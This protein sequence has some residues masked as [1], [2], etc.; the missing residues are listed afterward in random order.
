MKKALML[1]WF[2]GSLSSALAQQRLSND[3]YQAQLLGDGAV[4][5]KAGDSPA[6]KFRPVFTVMFRADDPDIKQTFPPGKVENMPVPNWKAVHGN[7]RTWDFFQAAESANVVASKAE[8][9]RAGKVRWRFAGDGPFQLE[10]ELSLAAGRGEP[11]IAFRFTPKRDGWYSIGY[12]G[13]PQW[14]PSELDEVWQPWIWQEKRF[15]RQSFFSSEHMCPLPATLIRKGSVTV[16]VAADP[17]ESPYRMPNR[18]NARFGVLVRNQNGAAQPMIFAPVLGRAASQMKAGEAFTFKLRLLVHAGTIFDAYKHLARN[19]YGFRDY[20]EN[21]GGSLNDTLENFISYA[22]NDYYS[23]WVEELKGFDYTSDVERTVKVVSALHPLSLAFITDNEE[24]Y[25]RRALPIIE[26]LMSREKY[27]FSIVEGETRQ[28]PSHALKG[29]AAE[30]SELAALYLMSQQRSDVFRHYALKL[31]DKRRAL[32]LEVVSEGASWQSLLG[33]YRMTGDALYLNRAKEGADRYI[34]ER[35]N[36]PQ[37]DFSA[38]NPKTGW[39]FW[40][41]YTPKWIDLLELYEE[42]REQRYLE[43][44]AV[45]ARLYTNYVWL[46]PRIPPGSVIANKGNKA[47]VGWRR[48]SRDPQ[49]MAVPEQ[50]VPAWRLSQI[51]LTPEASNTFEGN[52][53]VFLTHYAAYF[54]RLAYYTGDTFFRDIARAAV[55][56]RYENY[57]GYDINVEFTTLYARP[58]YPLRPYH[59]FTYN[60]VYY[61]HVWPHIALLMDYLLTEAFTKSEGR[62]EFPPRYAE[63]YAYLKSKVYGDRPGRF[64][65]DDGVRLWMPAKL[66]R[67]DN[68][69]AN[70]VAGYGNGNLYLALVNQSD[71]TIDVKLRLNP[72]VVPFDEAKSYRVRVW[73]ENKTAH[74]TTMR[75]G[76][77]GVTIAPRGITALAVDGLKVTPLFQPQVFNAGAARLSAASHAEI[78]TPFGKLTSMLI[79]FGS[80][81]TSGYVWLE[82]TEKELK[83]ARLNV[84]QDGEW[85]QMIDAQYPFEFSLP[86]KGDDPNIEFWVEGVTLDGRSVR[87]ASVA[88]KK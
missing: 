14:P 2:L 57:P 45:G 56:G 80:S 28:S 81:L 70:Y 63:G 86:V 9:T 13:A 54:L 50:F 17:D 1:I 64:Y 19:L 58:D 12:T 21:V 41:D 43:A 3:H 85:K 25:R 16:G 44:A 72:N 39:E 79:S 36:R 33:L 88:L 31:L 55:V 61:N 22:M 5:L 37:S 71:K 49:P 35:I 77:I 4:E 24:I 29:P 7:D 74:G 84:K 52:P 48:A 76:E 15:P 11:L 75:H 6:Y 38:I 32:N 30:I 42:T 83:E 47:A 27:L 78:N 51:G 23:G 46:H 53:A 65:A 26:Y 40:V 67:A 59:Q 8:V 18:D 20:R 73:Q 34:A 66:L 69:Q 62:I 10:A 68:I 87:S 60:Q 82:A